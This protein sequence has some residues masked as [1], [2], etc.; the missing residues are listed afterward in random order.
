MGKKKVVEKKGMEEREEGAGKNP[1]IFG[2]KLV[3]ISL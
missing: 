1:V 2:K 3:T